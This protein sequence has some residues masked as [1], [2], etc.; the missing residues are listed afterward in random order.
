VDA[1]VSAVAACR[2][3]TV[4]DIGCGWG[5]LA[6]ALAR[7]SDAAVLGID[8]N[9][10]FLARA[11]SSLDAQ[12]L[13]GRI[14]FREASAADL[15][16]ERFDT[17]LCVG[18]SQAFG[19]PRQALGQCAARLNDDG[20]LL[21][22]EGVWA[23]EP[24]PAF[25]EFLGIDRSLYWPIDAAETVFADAGLAIRRV[26]VTSES[27]WLAYE[28][29]IHRGRLR[30]AQTLDPAEAEEVRART[31]TWTSAWQRWGRHCLG[32]VGYVASRRG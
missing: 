4:L 32:F 15:G 1:L 24:P 18:A 8:V 22:A 26:E 13:I 9:A 25:L 11:R 3:R 17:V 31:A 20:V 7:V 29:A 10:E 2:P 14:E 23:A 28:D 16:D 27:S 12:A 5:S 30:F 19:T 6:M 21:F